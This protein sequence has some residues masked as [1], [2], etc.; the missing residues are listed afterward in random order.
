MYVLCQSAE[1][2]A[3]GIHQIE[4]ENVDLKSRETIERRNDDTMRL[5]DSHAADAIAAELP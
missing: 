4:T 3:T 5:N 2:D 1:L